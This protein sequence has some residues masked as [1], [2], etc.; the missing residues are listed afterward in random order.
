MNLLVDNNFLILD[1]G[2]K[3][4][5]FNATWCSLE[6]TNDSVIIT[7]Q[8]KIGNSGVS[9]SILFTDFQYDSVNYSTET[10]IFNILKDKIG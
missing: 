5:Y 8:G 2:V 6:F 4:K 3:K 7:D 10:T 1:N 9:E